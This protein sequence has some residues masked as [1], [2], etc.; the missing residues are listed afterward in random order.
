M[1]TQI[2]SRQVRSSSVHRARKLEEIGKAEVDVEVEAEAAEVVEEKEEDEEE[3]ETKGSRNSC[4]KI[5][6]PSPGRWGTK[7]RNPTMCMTLLLTSLLS[8]TSR[9]RQHRWRGA[10]ADAQDAA[11]NAQPARL[12]YLVNIVLPAA[13]R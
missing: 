9:Q 10:A 3:V 7:R 2:G 5:E 1:P 4:D 11:S 12:Q 13:N 8:P 6:Q